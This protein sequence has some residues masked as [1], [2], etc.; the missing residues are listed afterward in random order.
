MILDDVGN[1][2]VLVGVICWIVGFFTYRF[3]IEDR[4]K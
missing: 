2:I 3:V 1:I 4:S